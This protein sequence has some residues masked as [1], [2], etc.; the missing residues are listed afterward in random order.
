MIACLGKI[1]TAGVHHSQGRFCIDAAVVFHHVD[2]LAVHGSGSGQQFMLQVL[3]GHIVQVAVVLNNAGIPGI[4]L[5]QTQNIRAVDGAGSVGILLGNDHID[6]LFQQ[7]IAAVGANLS[8]GV[9][10]IFQTLDNDLALGISG[11][12]GDKVGGFRL[13]GHMIHH[14]INAFVLVQL[15]FHKVVISFILDQKLHL[16][17]IALAVAEQF[18][19]VNA[20]GE[21]MAV[22]HQSIVVVLGAAFP[23]QD[24]LVIIA[25][26]TEHQIAAAVHLG[27]IGDSYGAVGVAGVDH[28]SA[29]INSLGGVNLGQTGSGHFDGH[30]G[31][32]GIGSVVGNGKFAVSLRPLGNGIHAGGIGEE[33]QNHIA[34]VVGQTLGQGIHKG[35]AGQVGAF[36]GDGGKGGNDLVVDGVTSGSGAGM[37][38]AVGDAGSGTLMLAGVVLILPQGLFQRGNA[39]Q[40]LGIQ[41]NVVNPAGA[42]VGGV[43][44]V[45]G[46]HGDGYQEGIGGGH[47][48]F[49]NLGFHNQIQTQILIFCLGLAVGIGQR[50]GSAAVCGDV[51]FQS[52]LNHSGIGFQSRSQSVDQH[53]GLIVILGGIQLVSVGIATQAIFQPQGLQEVRAL[54][55]VNGVQNLYMAVGA[56][57]IF[58]LGELDNIRNLDIA[59]LH[60]LYG[61][62]VAGFAVAQGGVTAAQHIVDA[63][64]IEHAGGHIGGIPNAVLFGV[65]Q[66][67]LVN[68]KGAGS[69]FI[70]GSVLQFGGGNGNRKLSSKVRAISRDR[71][72]VSFFI[73]TFSFHR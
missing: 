65:G 18:G 16:G 64:L 26:V 24:N 12:D 19:Q 7:H 15:G 14:I 27:G 40:V 35:V 54:G 13:V 32:P 55:L 21:H 34:L 62:A 51:G 33:L 9:G 39:G 56:A 29:G 1:K 25:L 8:Q 2:L 42:A 58:G 37:G 20:V 31:I 67:V 59:E 69:G 41:G 38:I 46:G 11:L 47:D 10:V 6:A 5:N 72:F 4:I 28:G 45:H 49:G 30:N 23:G 70:D 52:V 60:T 48:H 43:G 61:I 66:V 50:H 63:G 68:G 53:I 44:A 36:G 17:E 57:V 71:I 3:L 73:L 22:I